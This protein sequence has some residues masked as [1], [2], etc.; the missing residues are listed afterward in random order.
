M[1]ERRMFAKTIVLSDAF[2][3]M[4]MSSRCLYFTLG[5]FADDEG[6]VNNPKSIMRQCG[7]TADDMNV[8]IAKKFI[9]VFE[10]GVIVIKHWRLHNLI[11]SD[12][13]HETKYQAE[14]EL[15]CYDENGAYTL[16]TPI[17]TDV[18]TT[19]LPSDNQVGDKWD[20][21]V[22]LG[23]DRIGKNI[24]SPLPKKEDA[25]LNQVVDY[26]NQKAG[27]NFKA[28]SKATQ[29]H[30]TARINEGYS[31]EDFK[32]VIDTKVKQWRDDPKMNMYLRPETLFAGHFEGYLNEAPK[33]KVVEKP[34]NI[35]LEKVIDCPWDD[36]TPEQEAAFDADREA[37]KY[38]DGWRIN[39]DGYW[40]NPEKGIV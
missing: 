38:E 6:F 3:D 31:L 21:E 13:R 19:C 23:K 30:I 35:N 37:H 39:D 28:S 2:L 14:K 4:P 20:T 17:N 9:L 24:Y 34:K 5:M 11:R 1:A 40:I 12:R 25:I 16:E 22:R 27:K 15:L 18:H 8:L 32:A 29:K 36:P 26:L 33:K 10:S 7:A